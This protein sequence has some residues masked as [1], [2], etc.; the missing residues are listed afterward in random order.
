MFFIARRY[1]RFLT[2]NDNPASGKDEK[3]PTKKRRGRPQ[4]PL[5][6]EA[7]ED[8]DETANYDA[9]GKKTG[10]RRK[11]QIQRG[12]VKE[13]EKPWEK[14][15]RA[16]TTKDGAI[17]GTTS[18]RKRGGATVVWYIVS[19]VLGAEVYAVCSVVVVVVLRRC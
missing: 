3:I 17:R 16:P 9:S 10:N 2:N 4:K 1:F 12:S 6:D 7:D 18:E 5:V 14:K 13:T 11:Q 15:E 8:D 19:V